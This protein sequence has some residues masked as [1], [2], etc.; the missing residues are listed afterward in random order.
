MTF[1]RLL[2]LFL[3]SVPILVTSNGCATLPNV[4]EK[5][6]AAPTTQGPSQIVSAKGLLSPEQSK[7]IMERL[8]RS[9][10]PTDILERHT[11]VVES[12]TES[13]LTKGNK[14]TLLGDGQAAYA[15]M[16]KAI[17]SARDHINLE[18][19]IIDDD[20][21]GRKFSDLLLKKRAEGVQ[22]NLIYDSVGSFNNPASF[23]KR[24]T[25]GGI[26]VVEF[27]PINPLKARGNWLLAHPDHRKIL[28]VDG[29]IA[30]TGGIN[31]S[32]VYSSRLSGGRVIEKGKPLPWRDTDIQ[33]EGPAVAEFQK[34]FLDTWSKQNGPK[35]SGGN[36]YPRAKEDGN[37]LVRVVGSIPGSDNR[38]MFIVYVAAIT[39]A[40]HSIHLTNAY[41]IPDD[42]ILKAFM[43]AARRGVDVKIILPGTT[44]SAVA[45]YAAQYNYSGLLEAGVK[46]YERRNA[47]LHAK[48]A[49]IDGV[50]STVGSTN[51]D[52]WSLL[53]NDEANA[54][55]L[56]RD[57]AAEMEKTFTK[58]IVESHQIKVEEWKERPLFWKI[59]EWFAHLFIRWL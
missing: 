17:Q 23:F 57:F 52:Y 51:M 21:V 33:I 1:I 47:L 39:F 53:S 19:Y 50:W 59:R 7:A 27:N 12:V 43:D 24:L 28:I 3:L 14:V 9:V 36:Y 55:V 34:L 54:V 20:D 18:T 31:I 41:F 15:A 11:A 16:F 49:V 56:N 4:T 35:L 29:K 37:A 40:E 48:T 26:K 42:Q 8:K 22:V 30:I 58:D 2:F 44:D 46:I 38:I 6:D 25:D 10:A 5:I 32:S 13:P 45:L